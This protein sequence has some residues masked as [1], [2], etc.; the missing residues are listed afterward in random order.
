MNPPSHITALPFIKAHSKEEAQR[1]INDGGR[2]AVDLDYPQAYEDLPDLMLSASKQRVSLLYR[3]QET[4]DVHS[5]SE[6]QDI[7][8]QPKN[9]SR[10]R[11]FVCQWIDMPDDL[12]KWRALHQAAEAHGDIITRRLA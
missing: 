3:A 2:Q 8:S 6:L 7:L 11:F 10:Q 4:V 12:A 9:T 1:L 5:M